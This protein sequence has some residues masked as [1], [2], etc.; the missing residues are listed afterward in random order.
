MSKKCIYLCLKTLYLLQ[1]YK[2]SFNFI[3]LLVGEA[4]TRRA[5]VRRQSAARP[6]TFQ[7]LCMDRRL[8]SDPHIKNVLIRIHY[9]FMA[10][11]VHSI[12]CILFQLILLS[13]VIITK[14]SS[15]Y[16]P[17]YMQFFLIFQKHSI[18]RKILRKH[19]YSQMINY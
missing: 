10:A 19:L 1:V 2:F 4:A 5:D 15:G 3:L 18:K 8:S 16:A 6:P 17:A 13:N 12:T 9:I 11:E 7:E 14:L